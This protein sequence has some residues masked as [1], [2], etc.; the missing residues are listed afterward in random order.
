MCNRLLCAAPRRAR[1]EVKTL[2]QKLVERLLQEATDEATK[3]GFCDTELGKA[4]RPAPLGRAVCHIEFLS[5][6]RRSAPARLF[7]KGGLEHPQVS[8]RGCVSALRMWS[9]RRVPR[10]GTRARAGASAARRATLT[11]SGMR[12]CAPRGVAVWRSTTPFVMRWRHGCG[13][14]G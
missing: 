9:R 3:K 6:R 4:G 12:W 13:I 8:P 11:A 2:I 5:S 14:S 10:A 1:R 7:E